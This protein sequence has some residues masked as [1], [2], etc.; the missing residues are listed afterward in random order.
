M[1]VRFFFFLFSLP[2]SL[3]FPLQNINCRVTR[4]SSV[5]NHKRNLTNISCR[6]SGNPLYVTSR[7]SYE[8]N[9]PE[10]A[11]NDNNFPWYVVPRS[12]FNQRATTFSSRLITARHW[13]RVNR[14][15]FA[16]YD[17]RICISQKSHFLGECG[18]LRED[19]TDV[20]WSLL[21]AGVRHPFFRRRKRERRN[22]AINDR[23][24]KIDRP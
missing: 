11:R 16:V 15:N 1:Y 24:N 3:F 6:F 4:R 23:S 20:R 21:E 7:A 2:I 19:G 17:V 18:I 12:S 13:S 14:V 8:P 5:C 10:T 9:S 22:K